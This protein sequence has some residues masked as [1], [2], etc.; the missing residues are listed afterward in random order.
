MPED[1]Q[2]RKEPVSKEENENIS[3]PPSLDE[4]KEVNFVMHQLK[5]LGPDGFPMLFYHKCWKT[6]KEDVVRYV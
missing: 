1:L 5:A 2:M 3:R 6:I 4:I